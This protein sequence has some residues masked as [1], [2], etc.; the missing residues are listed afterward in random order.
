VDA[1]R[2]RDKLREYYSEF[3]KEP[4]VISLPKGTYVPVF[5]EN[6]V[7]APNPTPLLHE[8]SITRRFPRWVWVASA[9]VLA[10]VLA[11]LAYRRLA[12]PVPIANAVRIT[13]FPGQK[14]D[15]AFSPD[16]ESLA[17]SSNGPEDPGFAD[18]WITTLSGGP[19]RRLT[20]TPQFT[21]TA[22]AWSPDG[23]EIAFVR[24]GMGVFI[25]PQN[26]GPERQVASSGSWVQWMPDGKS[27][28]VNDGDEPYSISSISLETGERRSLTQPR[29]GVGDLRFSVS[30][31][32]SRLAFIRYEHPGVGDLYTIPLSGGGEPQ[33]LTDLNSSQLAGLAWTPDGRDIIYSNVQLW[34]ISAS[35][36]Q[37]GRGSLISDRTS[38]V[39][40]LAIS[41]GHSGHLGR[42]VFQAS[43]YAG[44]FRIVDLTSPLY[45]GVFKGV[46]P[47]LAPPELYNAG[48]FIGAGPFSRDGTHFAFVAGPPP[49][50]LWTAA[51]DGTGPQKIVS[52]MASQLSPGQW[53][54]DGSRILYDA[55]IGGNNDVF[56]V[57]ATGGVP[58]R[59]TSELALDGVASWSHDGHWI[60][61]TSTRADGVIPDIWR[62]P[63]EGGLPV[64]VTYHGGIR[65]LASSDGKYIY[66]ADRPR[67]LSQEK[68][69]IMR[70]PTEGGTEEEVLKGLRPFEWSVAD[71]AIFFISHES[72]SDSLNRY[73]FASRK[74]ERI[75]RL[76]QRAAVDRQL[77]VSR[78]GHW[79]LI[80]QQETQ[81]D[82]M[83]L[84]NFN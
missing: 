4:V 23:R 76:A 28:L 77:N 84:D 6:G 15:P 61:Y 1:R 64:R 26:G 34:R 8:A 56:V 73:T 18:I 62:I 74:V 72:D 55:A 45:E 54:P 9:M 7:L 38:R 31:E 68:V 71:S 24:R 35:S 19:P 41:R 75:G 65:P 70:I 37:P 2:L 78:D 36:L 47:F 43:N 44:T 46:Q 32:G 83:L 39:E 81:S 10:G 33:R 59:L 21:E 52:V 50:Q 79:A 40:S 14:T 3:P 63:A 29:I 5:E 53:S 66:Y 22:P 12:R 69:R 16:G 27:V 20:E 42:L 17:F 58:R 13:R 49:L 30:P 57:D 48:P 11:V 51:Y 25:V 67:D 82:L 60:Y 80:N